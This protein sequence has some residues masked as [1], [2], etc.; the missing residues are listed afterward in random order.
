MIQDITIPRARARLKKTVHVNRRAEA[1]RRQLLGE[2]RKNLPSGLCTLSN[3]TGISKCSRTFLA[4]RI[5]RNPELHPKSPR[6][7]GSGEAGGELATPPPEARAA[8]RSCS[9]G[10]NQ[11]L[12]LHKARRRGFNQE[13]KHLT[14]ATGGRVR[15]GLAQHANSARSMKRRKSPR[16]AVIET[17]KT[18]DVCKPV[19]RKSCTNQLHPEPS[20]ASPG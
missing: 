10:E 17:L 1:I 7:H 8:V 5:T 11:N 13:V 3:G 20:P 6:T 18:P 2:R 4:H 15:P 9:L 16:S 19:G 12:D 14:T